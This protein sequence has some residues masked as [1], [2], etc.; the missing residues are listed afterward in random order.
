MKKLYYALANLIVQ[1]A[2]H[3]L[4]L[5]NWKITDALWYA[6]RYPPILHSISCITYEKAQIYDEYYHAYTGRHLY[7]YVEKSGSTVS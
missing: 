7:Y 1:E 2:Y 5:I 4:G 6:D 3:V